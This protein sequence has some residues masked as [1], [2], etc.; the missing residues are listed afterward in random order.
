MADGGERKIINIYQTLTSAMKRKETVLSNDMLYRIVREGFSLIEDIC[1]DTQVNW[2]RELENM[3]GGA[4]SKYKHSEVFEM[5]KKTTKKPV[6]LKES[7]QRWW[8]R[9]VRD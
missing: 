4:Q 5:F 8:G 1:T 7:K 2:E 6:W 9:M 3:G